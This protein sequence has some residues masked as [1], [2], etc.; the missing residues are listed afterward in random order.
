MLLTGSAL[1]GTALLST[2]VWQRYAAD[3][4]AA[5]NRLAG[6]GRTIEG[7]AGPIEYAEAGSGPPVLIVHGAGGGFDQG[8]LMAS[9]LSRAGWRVIAPSRFGYLGT[10]MPPDA[11][12]Q[13][14]ADALADLLDTLGIGTIPV[15]GGSA[16]ALPA[17]H[18][19]ARHPD[20]CRALVA[21][22]P[23]ASAQGLATAGVRG[24]TDTAIVNAMLSSD[25]LLWAALSLGGRRMTQLI[26]GTDPDLLQAASPAE[27]ARAN[28]IARAILPISRRA[29]GMRNDLRW[30]PAPPPL[31]L[32]AI[33]V[34]VLVLTM[35]DDR[36]NTLPV[37]RDIAVRVPGARLVTWPTGGHLWIGR[38]EALFAAI[39]GFFVG[40]ARS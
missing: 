6:M 32:A 9:P 13:A 2:F 20:R 30:I 24:S 8:L 34:P 35:E 11:S 1:A 16:G 38:E 12:P 37:A 26:L 31:D 40:T 39:T 4:Q 29:D 10:P 18:F 33:R 14:Q 19:A 28:A 21:L 17:L 5:R 15:I 22:V 27:Q 36:L 25:F 3:L 7:R 23:A